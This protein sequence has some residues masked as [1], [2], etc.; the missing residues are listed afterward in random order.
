VYFSPIPLAVLIAFIIIPAHK[1]VVFVTGAE[2]VGTVFYHTIVRVF[3]IRLVKTDLVQK[4]LRNMTAMA[5]KNAGKENMSPMPKH[6][7]Y[8][9]L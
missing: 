9:E 2:L 1:R 8:D 4:A 3:A 7:G 5:E 6:L